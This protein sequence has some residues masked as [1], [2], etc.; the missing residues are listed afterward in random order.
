MQ[1]YRQLFTKRH[2]SAP[3]K[4]YIFISTAMKDRITEQ[5]EY[6]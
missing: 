6:V 3:H 5:N 1:K 2:G 4:T